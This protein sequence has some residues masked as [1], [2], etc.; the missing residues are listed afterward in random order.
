MLAHGSAVVVEGVKGVPANEKSG[1]FYI[2]FLGSCF[3][4]MALWTKVEAFYSKIRTTLVRVTL[5]TIHLV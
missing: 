1:D 2:D 5:I 4:P 3:M